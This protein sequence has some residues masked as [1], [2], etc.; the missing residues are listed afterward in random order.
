VGG[1]LR[2]GN[3]TITGDLTVTGTVTTIDTT[4]LVIE[5]SLIR[6][7]RNQANTGSFTDA[8]DIGLYGVYGNTSVTYYSGLA[9]ESGTDNWVLFANNSSS[10]D[11]DGVETT[12]NK[13]TLYAYLNS[14]GLTTNST[15]VALT[16]NSTVNISL[17][18]NS[19]SLSTALAVNSGGTGVSSLTNNAILIGNT[20]GP[21]TQLTSSTEGHVLQISSGA[22]AFGMLD[23]GTF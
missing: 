8:V 11:N 21:V 23:G 16:A 19:I 6:L 4:N 7:A 13:G 3:T 17:T 20:A 5:D 18:V 14:G 2:A 1:V 9:R 12:D 10:P 15:S 22:P